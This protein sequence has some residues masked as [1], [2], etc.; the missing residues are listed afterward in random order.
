MIYYS[1]VLELEIKAQISLMDEACY[2][3]SVKKRVHKHAQS[4]SEDSKTKMTCY[5]IVRAVAICTCM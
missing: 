1:F 2:Q 3:H 5:V 4:V